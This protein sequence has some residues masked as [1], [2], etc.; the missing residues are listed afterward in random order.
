MK[1]IHL[2]IAITLLAQ[3][4][5]A[6]DGPLRPVQLRCEYLVNPL[7][8]ETSAPR[9]SWRVES[10]QRGQRQTAYRILAASTAERLAKDEGDLWDSGKVVSDQTVNVPY[11]GQPPLS[12]CHWKVRVW[13]REDQ[14]SSLERPGLLGSRTSFA[15]A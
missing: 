8:I 12:L 2:L 11:G 13:D 6:A 15:G 14:E 10:D 3:A 7:G 9:L 4:A 1:P 5:L